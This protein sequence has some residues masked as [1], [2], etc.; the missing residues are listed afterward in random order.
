MNHILTLKSCRA[1]GELKG[2][3]PLTEQEYAILA[4]LAESCP[5]Q[6]EHFDEVSWL[7][8]FRIPLEPKVRLLDDREHTISALVIYN[9]S[10]CV[11]LIGDA[12]LETHYLRYPG[13]LI[14]A[15]GEIMAKMKDGKEY[16]NLRPRGWMI[17]PVKSNDVSPEIKN[18]KVKKKNGC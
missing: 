11:G 12:E 9:K 17:F 7:Y 14:F 5:L 3:E 4:Q 10:T 15:V 18:E 13:A 8:P 2:K 6:G 16:K 1:L